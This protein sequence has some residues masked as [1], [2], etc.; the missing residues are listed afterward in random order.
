MRLPLEILLVEDNPQEAE[1]TIRA[2]KTRTLANHVVHVQDGQQALDFLFGTGSYAGS[3]AYELPK[4]VL[5]DLKLPK[6]DGI[7]VLRQMRAD[8]RTRLVPV[9]VLTSSRQDRDVIE[10]YQLGANSYIVKPVDFENFLEVISNMVTYWLLINQ[11][12]SL[13]L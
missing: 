8:K 13:K 5:L 3:A 7:E 6:L 12:P 4:V 2:L 1:L 9:V 11:L 10:A